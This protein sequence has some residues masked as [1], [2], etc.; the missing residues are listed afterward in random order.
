MEKLSNN[1]TLEEMTNSYKAK[2]KG[3]KNIPNEV[4]KEN[5][6]TLC[7]YILQP[8]RDKYDKP[9]IVTSGYRCKAL[10]DAVGGARTSD[11]INGDA[12]DIICSDNKELYRIIVH[13]I[14]S[15]VIEVGQLIN[16]HNY[17]WIHISN[18]TEKHYN[19]IFKID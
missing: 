9:I 5:L 8:I 17:K 18:P 16:E 19:E 1:F 12:A 7:Q 3:I 4:E 2:S 15:K 13:L 11:H 6:R 10:N 14:A